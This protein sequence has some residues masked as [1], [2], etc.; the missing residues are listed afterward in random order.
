M[1]RSSSTTKTVDDVALFQTRGSCCALSGAAELRLG[2]ETLGKARQ[3]LGPDGLVQMHT[4]VAGNLAQAIG[5]DVACQDN[6]RDCV[7]EPASAALR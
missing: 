6:G 3:L 1:A 5:R 7:L 2:K 4:A